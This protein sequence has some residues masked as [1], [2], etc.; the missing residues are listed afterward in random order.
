MSLAYKRK[1][2]RPAGNVRLLCVISHP[3]LKI[4]YLLT[5]QGP[6]RAS[7]APCRQASLEVSSFITPLPLPQPIC[8]GSY[9]RPGGGVALKASTPSSGSREGVGSSSQGLRP[10]CSLE[11]RTYPGHWD[12]TP[13]LA[14]RPDLCSPGPC[15]LP[16]PQL[17]SLPWLS[18]ACHWPPFCPI[19]TDSSVPAQNLC[20][21]P[22][23]C[24]GCSP[25]TTHLGA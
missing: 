8:P 25:Q 7:K 2:C 16:R 19:N 9:G 17:I 5:H 6:G 18:L 11:H 4:K 22:S 14:S 13:A 20:P 23:F 15:C 24:P 12:P 10:L 21:C 1:P 3:L